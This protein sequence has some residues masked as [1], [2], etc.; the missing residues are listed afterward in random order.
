MVTVI[1]SVL[2][3]KNPVLRTYHSSVQEQNQCE[4][5][6]YMI[7][8]PPQP[9]LQSC[10]QNNPHF[11]VYQ[12]CGKQHKTYPGFV[13]AFIGNISS[14]VVLDSL[15]PTLKSQPSPFFLISAS[16]G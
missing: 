13:V 3:K 9:F 12:I 14:F 10:Y 4:C 8:R 1:T 15:P 16:K 5:F 7:I 11:Q 6:G 2:K